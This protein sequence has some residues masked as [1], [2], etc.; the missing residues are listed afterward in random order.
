MCFPTLP[1]FDAPQLETWLAVLRELLTRTEGEQIVICHSLSV[2]L[3]LHHAQSTSTAPVERLLLVAPPGPSVGVP[4][5]ENFFPAPIDKAALQRSARNTQLVCT[6]ADP[7]CSERASLFY[8]EPL[9]IATEL[10]PPEAGHINVASGYG[11]WPFVE[12]WCL[13]NSDLRPAL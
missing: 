4:E 11:S 12:Q 10:L 9:G 5:V 8:G 7:Y 13:G 6:D 1:D 2:L 3:W